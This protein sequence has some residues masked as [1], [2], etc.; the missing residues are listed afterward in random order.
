MAYRMN[1]LGYWSSR[2]FLFFFSLSS[3]VQYNTS[4]QGL[5]GR[6]KMEHISEYSRFIL[7]DTLAL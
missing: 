7:H 4:T 6:T 3:G 1:S 2:V 5:L